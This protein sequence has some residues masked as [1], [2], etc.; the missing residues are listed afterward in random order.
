MKINYQLIFPDHFG[1]FF[2]MFYSCS[3]ILT[4][5]PFIYFQFPEFLLEPKGKISSVTVLTKI[6]TLKVIHV[7]ESFFL[8]YSTLMWG[9]N[10]L[11]YP[12]NNS[13]I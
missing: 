3:S 8:R 7:E 11:D 1:N 5:F 13:I 4:R 6:Q 12:E 2:F 9:H 10:S